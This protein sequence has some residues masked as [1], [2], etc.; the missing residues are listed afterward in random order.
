MPCDNSAIR[1]SLR[2][3]AMNLDRVQCIYSALAHAIRTTTTH[4]PE[5]MGD[6]LAADN[7][8]AGTMAR[9]GHDGSGT[10]D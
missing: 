6:T 3:E 2:T 8:I 1:M 4:R 5:E 7:F 9:H 10:G